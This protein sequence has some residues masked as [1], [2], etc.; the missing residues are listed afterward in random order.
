MNTGTL[1]YLEQYR[2]AWT[3]ETVTLAASLTED[4]S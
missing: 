2:P 3:A 4:D 1:T